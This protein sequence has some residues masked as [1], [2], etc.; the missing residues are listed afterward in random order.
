[1]RDTAPLPWPA[2]LAGTLAGLS[3]QAI[4]ATWSPFAFAVGIPCLLLLSSEW[5]WR[6]AQGHHPRPDLLAPLLALGYALAWAAGT[7]W[8]ALG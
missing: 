8:R 3:A 1:M 7:A 6:W 4:P 5:T 2:A